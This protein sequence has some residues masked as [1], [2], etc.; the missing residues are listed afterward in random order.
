MAQK[1]TKTETVLD[2]PPYAAG[3]DLEQASNLLFQTPGVSI[4]RLLWRNRLFVAWITGVG[5]ALA[6]VM[7]LLTPNRYTSTERIMPPDDQSAS[8]LETMAAALSSGPGGMGAI[9]DQ[10][11]ELKN[12]SDV[13]L[14]IL[15]SRTTQD[16]IINQFGLRSLYGDKRIE[17]ARNDLTA[18]TSIEVDRKSLIITIA[19]TDRDPHRAALV[20]QAYSD[21]LNDLLTQLNTS[22]ARRERTF[23]EERL[24]QVQADLE[25]AEQEFSQFASRNTAV[26]IKEQEK[27]MVD[28]AATIQGEL[29]ATQAEL[30][31]LRQIYT[32]DNVR[33]R[34]LSARLSELKQQLQRLSGPGNGDAS[35]SGTDSP[36]PSIRQLPVLGVTYAD[37]YRQTV[38]D[39]SIFETLTKEYEL[40]KVQEAKEIPTVKILDPPDVPEE[41]SYPPRSL[42]VFTGAVLAVLAASA[43]VIVRDRWNETDSGDP[44]KQLVQEIFQA[45]PDIRLWM[46][47]NGSRVG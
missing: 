25:N 7:A 39:E 44:R 37:L 40:A 6:I 19:V 32:D 29:V 17:D 42:V 46:R 45:C 9:A 26:D 47:R 5:I 11:L 43:W 28:S 15:Q 36:Y 8:G 24:R 4:A 16:K 21:S 2:V 34:S 31:G 23:L 14:G 41:K 38:I 18:R 30:E 35:P 10:F 3:G 22:G 12:S 1:L 27:A 20:A 13:F 33:I